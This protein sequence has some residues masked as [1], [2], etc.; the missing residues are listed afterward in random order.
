[1]HF[2]SDPGRL[3]NGVQLVSVLGT[4]HLRVR[5]GGRKTGQNGRIDKSCDRLQKQHRRSENRQWERASN[6]KGS[7]RDSQQTV[8]RPLTH[9][10][11]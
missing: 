1:M 5:A 9:Y 8:P 3:H 6:H 7:D 10:R 2:H 4:T 11:A